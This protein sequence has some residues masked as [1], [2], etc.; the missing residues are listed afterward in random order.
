MQEIDKNVEFNDFRKDGFVQVQLK[1]DAEN[2][3][4]VNFS[5]KY[6]DI[7]Q[8][9]VFV[10]AIVF[11]LVIGVLTVFSFR[12]VQKT[13]IRY[14]PAYSIHTEA[15]VETD[16]TVPPTEV[17]VKNYSIKDMLGSWKLVG[18]KETATTAIPYYSFAED[19]VAQENYGSITA[20]GR[21]KDLS[22]GKKKLVYIFIDDSLTGTYNFSFTGKKKKDYKLT[23]VDI[24]TSRTY[25]FE[26]AEAKAKKLSPSDD[27]KIDKKLVGYWLNKDIEKSYEFRSDGTAARVTGNVTTECIW[28]VNEDKVITIKY[29]KDEVKSINLDYIIKKDTLLINNTEYKKTEN[30]Q[31]QEQ[32]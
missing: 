27:F 6:L 13:S 24:S 20:A 23:L 28:T 11:V 14:V 1:E 30:N 15:T 2:A 22:E 4:P 16:E 9:N 10:L 29:I 5:P 26:R 32:E 19:G 7:A 25:E 21:Y 3:E 18:N 17:P 12:Y 8:L 31:E